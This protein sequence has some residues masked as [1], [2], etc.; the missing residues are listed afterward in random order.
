[1]IGASGGKSIV[2]LKN[3][4]TAKELNSYSFVIGGGVN[5][6]KVFN[7]GG[8]L[9]Y[10]ENKKFIGLRISGGLTK[11]ISDIKFKPPISAYGS[12]DNTIVTSSKIIKKSKEEIEKQIGYD[13]DKIAK[14]EKTALKNI[15]II[16]DIMVRISSNM[17]ELKN[18]RNNRR[19]WRR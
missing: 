19:T 13:L 15:L 7:I 14:D 10:D 9:L 1:M 6:L 5:T 8:E 18:D 17:E 4:N 2:F 11:S 12:I 16:S 3:V